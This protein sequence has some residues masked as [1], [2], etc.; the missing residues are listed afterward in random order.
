MILENFDRRTLAKMEIALERACSVVSTA[1]HKHRS[2][3]Y[4]ANRII[5]CA[6]NGNRDLDSLTKAA[7]AAAEEL[8]ATRMKN[9]LSRR[10][11]A[12]G[13]FSSGVQEPKSRIRGC[14][15]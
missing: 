6:S 3:R 15:I 4:V 11:G 12:A 9:S 7:I 8:N 13:H 10:S 5:Q 2:R 1:N 14:H